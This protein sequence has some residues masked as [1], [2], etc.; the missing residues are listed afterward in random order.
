M[1]E[2]KQIDK[3]ENGNVNISDSVIEIIATI[4]AKEVEGIT[5]LS[6]KLS[7][8]ITELFGKSNLNKGVYVKI[9][10]EEVIIDLHI[11]VDFGVKIPDVSWT[12][13]EAVKNNVESMTG[14]GV[15][16]VNIH[17]QGIKESKNIK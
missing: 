6:G 16:E 10:D 17:V 4:A 7:E 15:K 13:Q 2:K 5:G 12:V 8:E 11:L 14:L 1:S 9:E 3:F